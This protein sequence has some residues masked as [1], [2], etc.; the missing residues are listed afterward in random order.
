MYAC[1]HYIHVV[2]VHACVANQVDEKDE[3]NVVECESERER[4]SR[5]R[6]RKKLSECVVCCL[7]IRC[8]KYA[9]K[10]MVFIKYAKT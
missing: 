5:S 8:A 2:H 3:V 9:H 7:C 6:A 10:L 4:E 1:I